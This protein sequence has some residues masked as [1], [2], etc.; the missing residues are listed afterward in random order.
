MKKKYK[1]SNKE[2]T[3]KWWKHKEIEIDMNHDKGELMVHFDSN[4]DTDMELGG[5]HS[6]NPGRRHV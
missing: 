2:Q 3:N 5:G 6:G 4:G 1:R